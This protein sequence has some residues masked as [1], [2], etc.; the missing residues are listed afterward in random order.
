MTQSAS[1][2]FAIQ[3]VNVDPEGRIT[4]TN[5][6]IAER[7][8]VAA[9]AKP[10]PQPNINCGGCNTVKGCGPLNNAPNCGGSAR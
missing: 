4:I 2:E 7:L 9:A 6:R 5:P 8:H 10:K 3:D 1:D